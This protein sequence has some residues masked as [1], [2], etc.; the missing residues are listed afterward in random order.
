V[1]ATV[2]QQA[3]A[4]FA[5]PMPGCRSLS[6]RLTL[7]LTLVLGLST[8]SAVGASAQEPSLPASIYEGSCEEPGETVASLEDVSP[9]T[10]SEIASSAELRTVAEVFG[11][12]V[13]TSYTTVP[14][15]FAEIAA[16]RHSIIVHARTDDGVAQIACG[17]VGG[18]DGALADVRVGLHEPGSSLSRGVA[19]LHDTGAGTIAASIILA[20][21]AGKT[22]PIGDV[23]VPI[24]EFLYVPNPLEISRG[25]TVTWTNEDS[26][27]HTATATEGAFDSA[28]M[29][30]GDTWSF[31][32]DAPG[33]FDYF[34]AF[35]PLMR[36]TV[37]VQ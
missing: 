3:V 21:P 11:G 5:G 9:G 31:T 16:G 12:S 33:T 17:E 18:F 35:H 2:D 7:A 23:G 20:A 10:S 24:R 34:C 37:V 19:W 28:Y 15:A 13:M 30:Q 25:T 32:F 14:R 36:A 26:T 29:A 6:K 4:G 1:P 8:V 27:P 22:A